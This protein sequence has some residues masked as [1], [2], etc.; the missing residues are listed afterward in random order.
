MPLLLSCIIILGLTLNGCVSSPTQSLP[1][2][3]ITKTEI[4]Q[5]YPEFP[6]MKP[7]PPLNLEAFSWEYPR[8]P[9]KNVPKSIERCLSVPDSERNNAFWERCGEH[10]PQIDSNIFMGLSDKD[11]RTFQLNWT[12]LRARL[13]QYRARIKEINRQRTEWRQKAEEERQKYL[14]LQNKQNQGE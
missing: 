3:T 14:Q 1:V 8:D 4:I 13:K 10:P 6:N 2:R 11:F 12:K 7:L 5:E 9:T